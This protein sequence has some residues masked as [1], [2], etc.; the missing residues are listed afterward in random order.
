MGSRIKPVAINPA[1][2]PLSIEPTIQWASDDTAVRPLNV[3][4]KVAQIA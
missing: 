1:E 2:M 3:A 4:L